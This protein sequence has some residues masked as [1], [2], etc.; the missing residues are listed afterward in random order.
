MPPHLPIARR[1]AHIVTH[2]GVTIEDPYPP[3]LVTASLSNPRVTYWEPAKRM[4][5][6]RATTTDSN[7]MLLKTNMG[8]GTAASQAA[9]YRSKS[10]GEIRLLDHATAW[11]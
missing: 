5:K 7:L 1:V 2:H 6:L 10:S 8:L 9:T 3:M 4:A 11:Q